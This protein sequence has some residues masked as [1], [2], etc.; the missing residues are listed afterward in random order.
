MTAGVFNKV[1][2]TQKMAENSHRPQGGSTCSNQ[3]TITSP[4]VENRS[5]RGSLPRNGCHNPGR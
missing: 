4:H 5:Y 1:A 2:T 3:R